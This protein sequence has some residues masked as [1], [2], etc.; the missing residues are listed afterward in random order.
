MG[1]RC[2]DCRYWTSSSPST[3]CSVKF[4]EPTVTPECEGRQ[5]SKAKAKA[6]RNERRSI[7]G[8]VRAAQ[9][10][11]NQSED[12]VCGKGHEGGRNRANKNYPVID[13]GEPAEDK[14]SQTTGA[15]GRGNGGQTYREHSRNA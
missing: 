12:C 4:L 13:H 6:A 3:S 7:L 2:N 10:T 14:F 9:A 15:N 8:M 1:A 5:P 11:L